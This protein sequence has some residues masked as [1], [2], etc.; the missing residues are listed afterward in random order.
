[1]I[2]DPNL[3]PVDRRD[4]VETLQLSTAGGLTQFGAYIEVL[5]PGAWSSDRHWH[6]AE[7]E[8]LFVLEGLGTLH[9]DAGM[10][11]LHAHDAICW[12]HGAP[13]GHRIGNRSDAPLR[14][15]IVGSR[16]LEDV[17]TYPD[18][19]RRQ[20]NTA[21]EWRVEDADGTR[22]RGGDLP[23]A[24]LGLPAA[25]GQNY[26]G[27]HRP[28]LLPAA[29]RLWALESNY[30][31]P[32]LGGGLGDCHHAVLGDAG[33]LTQFGAHLERLPVGGFSSF[34]HWHQAEDELVLI[35]SGHPTLIEDT[36]TQLSPGDMVCWPAGVPIGHHLHNRSLDEAVYL[37]LGTRLPRDTIHYP[38]H[39]LIA[40]KDRAARHYNNVEGMVRSAGDDR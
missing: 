12:R 20:V 13:N 32:I 33:G 37:T 4:G 31:H 36:A 10:Q 28:S 40:H 29:T 35:L 9:D 34:R 5:A 23:P 17:C 7:D 25:W 18:S 16:A 26:D 24:L 1:M 15:L 2:V 19:G 8:F 11:D 14:Y 21:T 22:L 27:T 6:S 38:D 39:D 3:A 30:H